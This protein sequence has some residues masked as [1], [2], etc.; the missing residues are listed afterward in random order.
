MAQGKVV[1]SF[2]MF[3]GDPAFDRVVE[4]IKDGKMIEG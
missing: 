4:A 1:V 2:D 3:L